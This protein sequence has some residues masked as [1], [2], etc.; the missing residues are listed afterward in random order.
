MMLKKVTKSGL[1]LRSTKIEIFRRAEAHKKESVQNFARGLV[2]M[3]Q[4]LIEIQALQR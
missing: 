3:G 2:E 4:N 1:A